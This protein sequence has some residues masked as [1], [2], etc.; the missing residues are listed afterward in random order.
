MMSS[1]LQEKNDDALD[2]VLQ[3]MRHGRD[4]II[5]DATGM[6]SGTRALAKHLYL[7]D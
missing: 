1:M 4:S 6:V 5:F 3:A 7:A 2:P